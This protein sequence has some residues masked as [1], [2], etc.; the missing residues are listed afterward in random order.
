M[1]LFLTM[2]EEP[3]IRLRLE[4]LYDKYE[5]E[6]HYEAYSVL[7]HEADAEDAVQDAFFRI[8]KNIDRLQNLKDDELRWYVLCVAK[9]AAIDYYRKKKIQWQM[10]KE[11]DEDSISLISKETTEQNNNLYEK[12]AQLPERE[13]DVVML[14]YIYGFRYKEIANLLGVSAET[15]KKALIRAKSKIKIICKEEGLFND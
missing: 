15:V 7:H 2:I 4:E 10:E 9:N 13:K 14:K 5:Q 1:L 6:M 12:I 11:Y 8:W 3:R